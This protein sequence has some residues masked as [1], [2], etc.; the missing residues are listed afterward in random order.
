MPT[1]SHWPNRD[2]PFDNSRSEVIAHI[3]ERFGLDVNFAIRVFDYARY[4]KVIVFDPTT[5]L[6]CGAKGGAL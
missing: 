4:K 1:L 6:W 3:R 2:Q 5:K